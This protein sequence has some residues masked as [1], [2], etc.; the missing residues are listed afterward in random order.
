MQSS[1]TDEKHWRIIEK[2]LSSFLKSIE[3]ISW[4]NQLKMFQFAEK[5]G[6]HITR[7]GFYSPIPTL[8]E[9]SDDL[10]EIKDYHIDWNEDVQC[11]L[12]NVLKNYSL[13]FRQ[14]VDNG[15]YNM[16]N[17]TFEHHDTPLYYAIIR[18]FKPKKIIEVGA[19]NSTKLAYYASLQNPA[20]KITSIDP[21]VLENLEKEFSNSIKFIKKP[22]QK[23]PI[24]L[25]EELS[26][27]DILFID[28]SHV[29]KVGSDVNFLYLQVLPVLKS[30]VLIH[31]HDIFLPQVYSREWLTDYLL[32]W[33]EQFL[34]NAFLIGNKDYEV[35]LANN[36][37]DKK[38]PE[39]LKEFYDL[40]D[41]HGGGSFWIRKNNH[42]E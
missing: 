6:Y 32:F 23:I 41:D 7:T 9:L 17:G 4:Q 12:L 26:N 1:N 27:N 24:S 37:L 2:N 19:G 10:F 35:L 31:I 16:K 42:K 20:S 39:K 28:S 11:D 18:H 8:S 21:F 25:F 3:T 13:E 22:V 40:G 29:S 34:L 15:K 14:L 36:F 30:G 5:Q 33:N 38:F